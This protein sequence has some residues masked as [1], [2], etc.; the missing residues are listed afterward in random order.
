[1]EA[2]WKVI[3]SLNIAV[4]SIARTFSWWSFILWT[5][6]FDTRQCLVARFILCAA[7]VCMI[8]SGII[9]HGYTGSRMVRLRRSLYH[10][11][12]RP[13]QKD[14]HAY[15]RFGLSRIRTDCVPLWLSPSVCSLTGNRNCLSIHVCTLSRR[16]EGFLQPSTTPKSSHSRKS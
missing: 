2:T 14:R 4:L 16:R 6:Q 15:F 3:L 9:V 7:Y 13:T 8:L 1:M 12:G 5:T 10:S 11:P